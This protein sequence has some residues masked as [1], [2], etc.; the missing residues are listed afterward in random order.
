MK[1]ECAQM[2]A[3]ILNRAAV[4]K[5]V[6]LIAL[7]F[8]GST[9]AVERLFTTH[10]DRQVL[11]T[12][13]FGRTQ[14]NDDETVVQ[15]QSLKLNGVVRINQMTPNI[16]LN[17]S[18]GNLEE[19]S[20][21]SLGKGSNSRAIQLELLNRNV[22]VSLKPGQKLDLLTGKHEEAFNGPQLETSGKDSGK[23]DAGTEL[24]G[25]KPKDTRKA[26]AEDEAP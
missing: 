13:R 26:P 15:R 9:L 24:D 23:Y 20:S 2:R 21:L 8:P 16:W 6:L 11:D 10:S 18:P 1:D 3:K 17:G 5:I 19:D 7:S 22:K 12:K 25:T 4:L 14:T